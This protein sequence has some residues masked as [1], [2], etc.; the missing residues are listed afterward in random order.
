MIPIQRAEH[1]TKEMSLKLTE[2]CNGP[3][4]RF[5]Q[6]IGSAEFIF[7][8][9]AESTANAGPHAAST[10]DADPVLTERGRQ[11]AEKLS[12]WLK[13]YDVRAVY[14]SDTS[15]ARATAMP[16]ETRFNLKR[17]EMPDINEWNIGKGGEVDESKLNAMFDRWRSGDF[18]TNLEGAP[19][20]E[21]LEELNTRVVPAF[22]IIFD[23]HRSEGG[24]I[25]VV[26]HGGSISWTMPAFAENVRLSYAM[27][28]YLENAGSVS[29]ISKED[30]PYITRWGAEYFIDAAM[31]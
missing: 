24:T 27:Q 3:V 11:Q 26:A 10:Q 21:T 15:R 20:S 19:Y 17:R 1:T 14:T 8:R 31:D 30:K 18:R 5:E 13:H 23:R 7:V 4:P 25:V 9:H 16:L 29:I 22:Q 28:N 6:Q 12:E 2:T